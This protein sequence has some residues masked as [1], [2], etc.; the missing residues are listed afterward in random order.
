MRAVIADIVPH[1][2]RASAYGYFAI[3]LGLGALAG[4]S[5]AGW[6]SAVSIPLLI[7]FTTVAQVVAL[8]VLVRLNRLTRVP[9]GH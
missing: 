9:L 5:V 8:G 3:A 2:S 1:G 4:G 6:L 7:G